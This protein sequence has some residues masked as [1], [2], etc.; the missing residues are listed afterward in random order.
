MFSVGALCHVHTLWHV[1]HF[2]D[3]LHST[4]QRVRRSRC[5]RCDALSQIGDIIIF[6]L[7]HNLR[8]MTGRCEFWVCLVGKLLWGLTFA[9]GDLGGV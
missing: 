7:V 3:T 6:R 2:T 8:N 4:L 5:S 1:L 9:V